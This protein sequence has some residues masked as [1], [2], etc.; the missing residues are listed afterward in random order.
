MGIYTE[1]FRLI[2]PASLVEVRDESLTDESLFDPNDTNPLLMG[3]W[4]E[5]T[6]GSK[7]KKM[8]RTTTGTIIP[9]AVY[10]EKGRTDMQAAKKAPI[11]FMGPYSAESLIIDPAG[12]W[13]L[14]CKLMAASVTYDGKTR[15]GLKVHAGAAEVVGRLLRT[16]TNNGGWLRFIRTLG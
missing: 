9:F 7:D 1:T 15:A 6:S 3:E 4:L 11:L 14:G 5:Y 2:T 16:P 12:A 13:G 10:G 8:A